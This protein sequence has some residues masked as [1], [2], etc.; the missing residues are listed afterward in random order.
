MSRLQTLWIDATLSVK[1]AELPSSFDKYCEPVYCEDQRRIEQ[2]LK[3]GMFDL[4]C[5]DFD[6]PDR[7]GLRLLKETKAAYPSI[8]IVMLTVQ[9]SE[10]LAIWAFR[11]KVW[12]YL[13]KPVPK[14]E[15]E[16][17]LVGVV[18]AVNHR[19]EQAGRAAAS[20]SDRIPDEISFLPKGDEASLAPAVFYIE[21]H[22]RSRIRSEE[23]AALCG[24]SPFRFS[25]L[26]KEVY[27][28]TF[29]DYLIGY[30]L[31]EACRLLENPGV[32]VADVA[33][34][35]G[36]SDPSYF[37]RVFRQRIGTAPSQLIGQSSDEVRRASE[38][39]AAQLP[40]VVL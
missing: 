2:L 32:N 29:R 35:V 6:Y 13:V 5:F 15:A 37:T 17:C 36:F 1:E 20:H 23:L 19:R 25:R 38:R 3:T 26:F 14:S 9:H 30:R 24:M 27:G 28:I 16:R 7:A 33:F 22:F 31:K 39:L 10:S 11:S 34:A 18:K 21:Q 12:D 4:I 40:E 8:P